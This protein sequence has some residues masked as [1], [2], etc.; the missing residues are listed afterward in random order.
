MTGIPDPGRASKAVAM[1]AGGWQHPAEPMTFE[2]GS[3]DIRAL[4]IDGEPWFVL[5]DVCRALTIGNVGNVAERLNRSGAAIRQ[6]DIRSGGQM[7]LVTLVDESGMYEAVI[8]SDK[9]EAVRFRRWITSEVLPA[10]RRTGSYSTTAALSGPELVAAALIEANRML[11]SKDERIAELEPKAEFYD[12]LMDAHGSYSL[13]QAARMVG[14]GRNVMMRECRR[15][16]ILQGNNLPYRRY[17]HHFKVIPGTRV[18]PKTGETIPTAT[19]HVLPSGVEFLRK[20]LA[21]RDALA[22]VK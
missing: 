13:A 18:H 7:R 19:T 3:D 21:D 6:T 10:I 11:G 22:V 1:V 8:R 14:W 20:K 17:D 2:F 16:G 4:V 12:E 5:S 15:M 9:P